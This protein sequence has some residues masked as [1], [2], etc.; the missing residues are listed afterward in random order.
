MNKVKITTLAGMSEQQILE[1]ISMSPLERLNLAFQISDFALEL[2]PD[3]ETI[4]EKS[5]SIEWIELH[6][7]SS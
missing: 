6:K 5:S 1:D 2:R 4:E 7:I 3:P